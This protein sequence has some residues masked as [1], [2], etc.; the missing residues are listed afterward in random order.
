MLLPLVSIVVLSLFL[1][2]FWCTGEAEAIPKTDGFA[3]DMFKDSP[4]PEINQQTE[5]GSA[6]NSQQ[7]ESSHPKNG[8]QPESGSPENGQ[9]PESSSPENGRKLESSISENVQQPESS[10]PAN[11]L[12]GYSATHSTMRYLFTAVTREHPG[13]AVVY[14]LQILMGTGLADA[15]DQISRETKEW[16]E[17]QSREMLGTYCIFFAFVLVYLLICFFFSLSLFLA[18]DGR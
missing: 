8:Q 1:F 10:N 9:Q 13:V 12:S 17:Q 15:D 11:V 5:S 18:Y 7:P 4:S 3:I 14:G 6:E 16:V 2:A